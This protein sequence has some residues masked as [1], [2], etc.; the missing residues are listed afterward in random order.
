MEYKILVPSVTWDKARQYFDSL[1][2]VVEGVDAIP[3]VQ[4]GKYFQNRLTTAVLNHTGVASTTDSHHQRHYTMMYHLLN[5]KKPQVFAESEMIGRAEDDWSPMELEILGD[6]SIAVPV[7]IFDDGKHYY[8]DAQVH[9]PPFEGTLLYVPGALLTNGHGEIPCD[10]SRIKSRDGHNRSIDPDLLNAFYERRIL[11]CLLYANQVCKDKSKKAFIT[12]PGLGCGQFAGSFRGQMGKLL[13]DAMEHILT[14][15]GE[16][17]DSIQ[18]LYYDPY[19][20]CNN[21]R[22]MIHN[23][24]FMV[25]PLCKTPTGKK[26][27]SQLCHPKVYEEEEFGDDF[28]DCEFF[29][30]VAWDHVSWPGNDFWKGSRATDDGVKAAATSSMGVMTG[31]EGFYDKQYREYRPPRNFTWWEDVVTAFSLEIEVR[32]G[33]NFLIL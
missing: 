31:Y 26:A 1:T 25:R 3:A 11:P 12:I 22:K 6:V 14:K 20:E 32:P 17:L 19:N 13:Q 15:H 24:V 5:T 27:K 21:Q 9:E 30:F 2:T 8:S 29:S 4:P 16:Q 33:D 18:A 28:S 23:I 10:L 7:T